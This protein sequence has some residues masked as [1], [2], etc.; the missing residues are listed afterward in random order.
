MDELLR[1][2]IIEDSIPDTFLLLKELRRNNFTL[3]WE[4]IYSPD[5]LHFMLGNRSWDI[6]ISDYYLPEF[7]A[8]KALEI[9][10]QTN[11]DIPFIVV[12][13]V[14]GENI[15][16][17][18]MKAGAHDYIMKGNLIR[19]S[20]V[21]RREI[22]DAHI[23][24]ERKKSEILLKRQGETIEAVI[25]GIAILEKGAFIYANRAYLR[26]FGY[27][28]IE[29]IVGKS[30]RHLY[31]PE[32]VERFENDIFPVLQQERAWQGEVIATRKD[33]S[34][35]DEGLSLTYTEE[36]LLISVCR[37][38]SELK[39][40]QEQIIYTSL[41]DPLTNLPNRTLLTERLE[42]AIQRSMRDETY[43]YAVLFLDLDRFKVINDS[44]GHVVGD[45]LLKAIGQKLTDY[46]RDIDFVARVGGDEFIIFLDNI[47]DPKTVVHITE[48]ILEDY[49]NPLIIDGNTIF[50]SLSIGI[51][52][53]TKEHIEASTLIRD[54]DLAMYRAKHQEKSSYVFFDTDMHVQAMKRLRIETDLHQ[55]IEKNE[56]ILYY[57]PIMNLVNNELVGF[58]AL[59]RWQ[60]PIHGCVPPSDFIP[61]AEDTG[62]I[63]PID[64]WVLN[65][66]CQQL[67]NWR[68][69]FS[70]AGQLEI[71]INLSILDLCKASLINDIDSILFDTGLDAH[72]VNIEV[73][74]TM[75][76]EEF[77][78]IIDILSKLKLRNI[79]ISIDDFGTGYSSLNYI[80]R[81]PVHTLKIDRSLIAKIH[82]NNRDYK[83]M[84]SMI[85]LSNQLDLTV[86]AEGIQTEEQLQLLQG[87]GCQ[88]GQGYFFSKPM[89]ADEIEANFLKPNV[90]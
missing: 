54:A 36:D 74:E 58:E 67:S 32:E 2:L 73:T 56:F 8:P 61:V 78:Q 63:V 17:S 30:W 66:A 49:K 47:N 72:S 70:N 57:Q 39:Q 87:I 43:R 38:I 37:D 48:R 13:G 68:H 44:L 51:V 21:V 7:D 26:L 81:L 62:L 12:S 27:N 82:E 31:S 6:I 59:I 33:G 45:K 75:L 55:A 52:M 83:V 84:N 64:S 76:I 42:F 15:A 90:V 24:A 35:F 29:E 25:D 88:L 65:E 53:G 18:L 10:K 9:V 80:H 89:P 3:D 22:R 23:R 1:V 69:K 19:L 46:L 71:N 4:R 85:F 41:H 28:N 60:H 14:I 20:E 34:R 77:E 11:L 16:V 5:S 79:T 40:A 86:I 50:V